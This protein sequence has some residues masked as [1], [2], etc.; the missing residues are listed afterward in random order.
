VR[1]GPPENTVAVTAVFSPGT[2]DLGYAE[3]RRDPSD[4]RR[5]LFEITSAMVETLG[6][7]EMAQGASRTRPL[8]G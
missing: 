8:A 2:K 4:R 3:R 6:R 1:M 7:A 5:H